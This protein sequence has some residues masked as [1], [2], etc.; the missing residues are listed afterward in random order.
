MA[1]KQLISPCGV[2]CARCVH[3]L[4]NENTAALAQVEKWSARLNIPIEIIT[5]KGCR[6]HTGQIPL[7][8][9]LFG[10]NHRCSIY[11]C[12]QEKKTEYCGICEQFP[13]DKR[14]PY[15]EKTELLDKNAQALLCP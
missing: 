2:N 6:A 9:H 5:C 3:Y 14:H 8:Q 15:F 12:A 4:A 13:C 10:D 7:Q 11:G 1:H